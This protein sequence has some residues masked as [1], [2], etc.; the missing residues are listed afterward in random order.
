MTLLI[1]GLVI[2]LGAHSVRIFAEGWR[3]GFIARRGEMAYKGLYTVM[4]LIGLVLLVWGYGAARA[5]PI[6]VWS[7]PRGMNHAAALLT[8]IAFVFL[9]AAYVPGNAI[10]AKLKHPMV[11][12]VKV[13]AFA[14][15][16][17]NG[18]LA[19][20]VLFGA[21]LLWAVLSFRAAR[22]RDWALNTVYP[23]GRAGPTVTTVIVGLALWAVF[24][25][26]AHA[27]LIGVAPLGR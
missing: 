21:F 18:R 3:A 16:I 14:H 10:K 27:W 2:F 15:L 13:W 4:S 19:D 20:I 7:P 6:D 24:A 1:L 23:P 26:W 17:S 8:L 25:M 9:V 5:T 11:L 12:S 22:G